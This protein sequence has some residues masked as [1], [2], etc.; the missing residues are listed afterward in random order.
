MYQK[1]KDNLHIDLNP[2]L[3]FEPE[4]NKA[5]KILNPDQKLELSEIIKKRDY[6]KLLSNYIF[7]DNFP[8]KISFLS[9]AYPQKILKN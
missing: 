3:Y 5:F 1:V 2:P 6:L 8:K 4:S 9:Q 7:I